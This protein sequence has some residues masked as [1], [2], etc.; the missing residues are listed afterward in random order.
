MKNQV[1]QSTSEKLVSMSAQDLQLTEQLTDMV[2]WMDEG[3]DPAPFDALWDARVALRNEM[4]ALLQRV[5]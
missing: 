2:I 1:A 3:S 4:L 5:L